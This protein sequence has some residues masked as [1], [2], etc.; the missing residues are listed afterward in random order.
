M[1]LRNAPVPVC[2][3]FAGSGTSLAVARAMGRRAVGVELQMGYVPLIQ[4]RVADAARPLLEADDA[5]TEEVRV[6]ALPLFEW[7]A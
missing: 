6:E 5:D 7:T 1:Y 2:D 3:P 4:R